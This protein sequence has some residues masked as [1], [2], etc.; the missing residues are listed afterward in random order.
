MPYTY[1]Y[2]RPAVTVDMIIL[3]PGHRKPEVLLIQRG[4]P[5]FE[6]QWALPGGFMDLEEEL[7]EAAARELF[8]ETGL[9]HIPLDEVGV[10]GKIGRDP[11]GRTVS[12]VF[13]A[14]L[15]HRPDVRAG[16]DAAEVGWFPLDRLPNLACDHGDTIERV[17]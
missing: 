6:S 12:V 3:T 14:R 1:D 13:L 9:E 16:D 5:P 7:E 17:I 8:E 4:H 15:D 11:R 10:F 2:P